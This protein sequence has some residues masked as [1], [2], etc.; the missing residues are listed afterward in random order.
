MPGGPPG[1][2]LRGRGAGAGLEDARR[3]AAEDLRAARAKAAALAAEAE[4]L[5]AAVHRE[6]AERSS[7]EAARVCRSK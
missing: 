5:E 7:A 2:H 6:R 4:T 3:V 1:L